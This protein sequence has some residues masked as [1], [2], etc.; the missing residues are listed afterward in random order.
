MNLLLL[1]IK[2]TLEDLKLGMDG[3]LNMTEKME[4]LAQCLEFN[5]LPGNWEEVAYFSKKPLLAWF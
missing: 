2:I 4:T 1:T 3:A 5:R